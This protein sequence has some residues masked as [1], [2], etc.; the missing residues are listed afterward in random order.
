MTANQT[1]E[2]TRKIF[3]VD[4]RGTELTPAQ[5]DQLRKDFEG[6][7]LNSAGPQLARFSVGSI[8][9][10]QPN[11]EKINGMIDIAQLGDVEC[12]IVGVTFIP[13]KVLYDIAVADS[14]SITGYYES[15]PMRGIDSFFILSGPRSHEGDP[16]AKDAEPPSICPH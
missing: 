11:V 4:T 3:F 7:D 2:E 16:I 6:R 12:K 9:Y 5:L 10:F 1:P 15:H 13:G 8:A 14:T